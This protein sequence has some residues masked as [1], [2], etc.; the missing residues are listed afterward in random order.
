MAD[1]R[2]RLEELH[3]LLRHALTLEL[4]TIP[5]YATACFSIQE[6][7]EYDRSAPEIVNA[8]PIE[9]IRQ[10]MVEEMLHMTLVANVLNAIG[11]APAL[12]DPK[13]VPTYP[14][15]LLPNGQGPEV[16]L[17]R[18][19]PE[20][21]KTFREIERGPPGLEPPLEN[22]TDAETIGAF[23]GCIIKRLEMLCAEVGEDVVFTGSLARQIGPYDYYGAGGEVIVVK[24]LCTAK[25]ALCEIIN[26]GEGADIGHRAGDKDWIPGE[27]R[28]DVAHFYKFNEIYCGRYYRPDDRLGEPPTG[29]NLVVDWSAVWPM[30]NDPKAADFADL[31]EVKAKVDAFNK[32]YSDFLRTLNCALDGHPENLVG[33]VP[34]MYQLKY[35][36]LELMRIPINDKGETAGPT[37]EFIGAP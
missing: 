17:R 3:D 6:Q 16:R 24:N 34:T 35:A 4:S 31:P 30:K 5:P 18:F 2:Q 8:E 22:C 32:T 12:N 11:G 19:T 21:I 13:W 20:Q 27:D 10:V 1:L 7:G 14:R 33:T 15:R 36:A 26:E 28:E 9:V 25:A 29:G 23:Y 37:W